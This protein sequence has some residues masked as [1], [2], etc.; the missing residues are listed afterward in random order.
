MTFGV[1]PPPDAAVAN[2][3]LRINRALRVMLHTRWSAAAWAEVRV[4]FRKALA[5][6]GLEAWAQVIGRG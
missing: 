2:P 4:E 1:S 3:W 6:D 5:P